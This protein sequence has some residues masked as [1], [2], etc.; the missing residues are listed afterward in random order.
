M[1]STIQQDCSLDLWPEAVAVLD[2]CSQV[3]C[4]CLKMFPEVT[5][6]PVRYTILGVLDMGKG[7]IA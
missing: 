6:L 3:I 5:N 1:S 4:S 7:E 2:G